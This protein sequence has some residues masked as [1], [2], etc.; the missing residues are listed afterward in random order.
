MT[1]TFRVSNYFEFVYRSL[2]NIFIKIS[3]LDDRTWYVQWSLMVQ[4]HGHLQW[5]RKEH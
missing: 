1:V 2:F 3:C 4:N 5:R